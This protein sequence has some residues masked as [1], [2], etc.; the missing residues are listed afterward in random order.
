MWRR[1]HGRKCSCVDAARRVL[2]PIVPVRAR[3]QG[4]VYVGG[5]CGR[6]GTIGATRSRLAGAV[7]TTGIARTICSALAFV[8][9]FSS[10]SKVDSRQSLVDSRVESAQDST[11]KE[12]Y[13][14]DEP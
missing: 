3:R 13:S 9:V 2:S 12:R 14:C 8:C 4:H 6:T 5:A 7:N 1:F 10:E 11:M